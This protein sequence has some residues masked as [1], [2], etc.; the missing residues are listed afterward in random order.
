MAG[1]TLSVLALVP[2]TTSAQELVAAEGLD[3]RRA[4][5]KA[6]GQAHYAA[7]SQ[8]GFAMQLCQSFGP[9]VQRDQ[10]CNQF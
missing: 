4:P 8:R 3:S 6:R 2:A 1:T 9:N 5:F 10:A 7:P